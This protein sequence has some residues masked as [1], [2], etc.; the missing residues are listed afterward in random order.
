MWKSSSSLVQRVPVLL[1]LAI[2]G[3]TE[4]A[5]KLIARGAQVNRLGWTPLHYAASKGQMEM[6]RMLRGD[7]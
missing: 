3:Q 6:A 4:R 1:R 5:K 2:A 7:L